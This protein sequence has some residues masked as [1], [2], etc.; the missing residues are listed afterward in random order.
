MGYQSETAGSIGVETSVGIFVVDS[1]VY[2]SEPDWVYW[3]GPLSETSWVYRS[4]PRSRTA[5]MENKLLAYE[6]EHH[7][8]G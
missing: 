5:S 7:G 6:E 8:R 4:E 2:R 1:R 3:L